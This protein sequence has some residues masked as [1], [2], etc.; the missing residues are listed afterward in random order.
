MVMLQILI[1]AAKIWEHTHLKAKMINATRWSST[2]QILKRYQQLL[3]F[4]RLLYSAFE[5]GDLTLIEVR[6]YFDTVIEQ[7]PVVSHLLGATAS[8]VQD[9]L[10]ESAIVK[11][12]SGKTPQMHADE[13][14]EVECLRISSETGALVRCDPSHLSL[15]ERAKKGSVLGSRPYISATYILRFCSLLKIFVT[16]W[17]QKQGTQYPAALRNSHQHIFSLNYFYMSWWPQMWKAEQ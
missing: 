14:T 2:F 7:F 8:I 4:L 3:P 12:Q 13:K 9:S 10:F 16:A 1:P 17:Y 15:P 6:G 11:L 5:R